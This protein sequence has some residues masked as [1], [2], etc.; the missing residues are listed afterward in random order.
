V[1]GIEIDQIPKVGEEPHFD[2][3]HLML[4]HEQGQQQDKQ[5]AEAEDR[6]QDRPAQPSII[7]M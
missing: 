2:E 7:I 3:L 4:A 1:A 6:C 5:Q